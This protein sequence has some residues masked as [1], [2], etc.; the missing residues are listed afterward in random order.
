MGFR[1]QTAC[2]HHVSGHECFVFAPGWAA[3]LPGH[4]QPLLPSQ[5][6]AAEKVWAENL[7]RAGPKG[8]PGCGSVAQR[9]GRLGRAPGPGIHCSASLMSCSAT[10]SLTA[11]PWAL[12]HYL[13]NEGRGPDGFQGPCAYN[14]NFHAYVSGRKGRFRTNRKQ[15][16]HSEARLSH[17]PKLSQTLGLGPDSRGAGGQVG[18]RRGRVSGSALEPACTHSQEVNRALA[19]H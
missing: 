5:S 7:L 1:N 4:Q 3:T 8:K 14:F 6:L 16:P 9:I 13:G 17:V 19:K 10:G 15:P 18:A 11:P 2:S 12:G